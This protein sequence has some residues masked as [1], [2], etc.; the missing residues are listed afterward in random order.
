MGGKKKKKKKSYEQK[1]KRRFSKI[2]VKGSDKN[3]SIKSN[4]VVFFCRTNVWTSQFIISPICKPEL[5]TALAAALIHD[6]R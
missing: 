4:S 1:H 3:N 5:I 2:D 6:Y